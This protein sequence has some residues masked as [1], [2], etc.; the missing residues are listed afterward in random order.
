MNCL[1]RHKLGRHLAT[2]RKIYANFGLCLSTMLWAVMRW[3][4]WCS[5]WWVVFIQ[6]ANCID[7]IIRITGRWSSCGLVEQICLNCPCLPQ[8]PCLSKPK[9]V[10][11]KKLRI[12]G[13]FFKPTSE[14]LTMVG[15]IF[16]KRK[17][18]LQIIWPKSLTVWFPYHSCF[19]NS[20]LA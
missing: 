19:H 13:Q 3:N 17:L 9:G 8:P 20:F 14:E 12:L 10:S 5:S 16:L 11:E 1:G 18:W 4:L 7:C 2:L 6:M 15:T